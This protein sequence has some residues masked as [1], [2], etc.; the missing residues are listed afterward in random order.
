[1]PEEFFAFNDAET[2]LEIRG[3]KVSHKGAN[4]KERAEILMT[5]PVEFVQKV[6]VW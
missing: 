3:E 6:D 4:G 1:M 2:G 5:L